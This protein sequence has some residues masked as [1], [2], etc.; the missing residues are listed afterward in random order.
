M[1]YSSAFKNIMKYILESEDIEL[2]KWAIVLQQLMEEAK[3]DNRK[4]S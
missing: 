2:P 3:N 4:R 1:I